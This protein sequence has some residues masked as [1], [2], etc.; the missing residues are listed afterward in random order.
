MGA[1]QA[2]ST[3]I[4]THQLESGRFICEVL[5]YGNGK[6]YEY[7]TPDFDTAHAAYRNAIMRLYQRHWKVLKDGKTEFVNP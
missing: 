1:V 2:F 3:D 4:R 5:E 7:K 6:F